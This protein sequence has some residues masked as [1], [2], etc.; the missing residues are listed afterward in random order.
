M[1]LAKYNFLKNPFLR[2]DEGASLTPSSIESKSTLNQCTNLRAKDVV[3]GLG[4][5]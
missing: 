2:Y 4:R 5:T 3:G 1:L